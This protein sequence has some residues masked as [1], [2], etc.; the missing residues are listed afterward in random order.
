MRAEALG[1][2]RDPIAFLDAQL[3]RAANGK[4]PGPRGIIAASAAS[5][6][7]SSMTSGTSSGVRR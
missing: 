4:G 1:E 5:A 3:A 6:G 7:I 2:R